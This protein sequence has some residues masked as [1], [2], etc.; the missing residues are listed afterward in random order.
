MEAAE[1][2]AAQVHQTMQ[3]QK[4]LAQAFEK[5]LG[6]QCEAAITSVKN[7]RTP[8]NLKETFNELVKLRTML[9]VSF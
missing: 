5:D 4:A 6:S 8:E 7:V 1:Q 9:T 2:E 3:A